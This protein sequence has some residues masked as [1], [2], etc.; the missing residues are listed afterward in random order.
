M[1]LQ[2][3][4]HCLTTA[5]MD[6]IEC[7]A[8]ICQADSELAAVHILGK[9]QACSGRL[10]A[11][12]TREAVAI[13]GCAG[14]PPLSSQFAGA[15]KALA[16]AQLCVDTTDP[17]HLNIVA[18]AIATMLTDYGSVSELVQLLDTVQASSGFFFTT[19]FVRQYAVALA[20]H[21]QLFSFKF[22]LK[23]VCCPALC[24]VFALA[25][26]RHSELT[27]S[28]W[29]KLSG[30]TKLAVVLIDIIIAACAKCAITAQD[31]GGV[32]SRESMHALHC[33][34][35]F[36]KRCKVPMAEETCG[37]AV[38]A[39]SVPIQHNYKAGVQPQDVV[40][41]CT[42]LL[43]HMN[44][45]TAKGGAWVGNALIRLQGQISNTIQSVWAIVLTMHAH[46]FLLEPCHTA[47]GNKLSGRAT[48]SRAVKIATR[49]ICVRLWP[50]SGKD[51][52]YKTFARVIA[53]ELDSCKTARANKLL[54]VQF[55]DFVS[56][57]AVNGAAFG[58]PIF[59]SGPAATQQLALPPLHGPPLRSGR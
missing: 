39:F 21:S 5:H 28:T 20:R 17:A 6:L 58:T 45:T 52:Y 19:S 38:V 9:Y 53:A 56:R 41:V 7:L 25:P 40:A 26:P 47:P 55:A 43:G 27:L 22:L 37:R 13:I 10:S 11:L 23:A 54:P 31:T 16:D 32:C 50:K 29:D 33:V 14:A 1:W 18:G 12:T 59:A 4:A 51:I 15:A 3:D 48:T 8:A 2:N 44:L 36:A 49:N 34:L 35:D 46:G 24:S 42:E 57:C 30:S